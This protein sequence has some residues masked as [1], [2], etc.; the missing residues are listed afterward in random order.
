M[1]FYATFNSILVI[2]RRQLTLFMSFLGFTSTRPG[3]EVSCP[4]TPHEKT[5]RIQCG[6][7]SGPLDYESNTL[8]LSHAGPLFTDI[9]TDIWTNRKAKN[10][11]PPVYRCGDIKNLKEAESIERQR[12][13]NMK[14]K[15]YLMQ[16]INL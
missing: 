11:M 3:S 12:Y 15:I 13:R 5:Q 7:N 1:V 8:P 9:Q 14:K 2:S 10:Y 6:S 4:R 16:T